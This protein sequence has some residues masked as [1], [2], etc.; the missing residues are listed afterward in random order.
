MVSTA[1]SRHHLFFAVSAIV[2]QTTGTRQHVRCQN[3]FVRFIF[4]DESLQCVFR[5]YGQAKLFQGLE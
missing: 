5:I 1:E 2:G 4:F 3:L